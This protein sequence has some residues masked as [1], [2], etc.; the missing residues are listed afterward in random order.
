MKPSNAQYAD[1]FD[2][3]ADEQLIEQATRLQDLY[4]AEELP[5]SLSWGRFSLQARHLSA[6]SRVEHRSL[7]HWFRPAFPSGVWVW[8]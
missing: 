3:H 4:T 2:N 6:S 8:A 5:S 1:L 7:S